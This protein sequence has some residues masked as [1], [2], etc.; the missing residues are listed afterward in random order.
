MADYGKMMALRR[1][2]W[3]SAKIADEMR[4]MDEEYCD[5][6]AERLDEIDFQI[7]RL[8]REYRRYASLVTT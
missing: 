4:M 6:V 5:A 8:E 2:G 1:A 3:S 7:S